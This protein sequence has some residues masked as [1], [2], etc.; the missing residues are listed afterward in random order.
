ML[1]KELI[2]ILTTEKPKSNLK[3]LVFINPLK[4][5]KNLHDFISYSQDK[6]FYKYMETEPKNK[7]EIKNYFDRVIKNDIKIKNNFLSQKF[8]FVKSLKLDKIIGSAKLSD[9]SLERKS[10]QWG[11]GV[12]SNFRKYNYLIKIQL[13]LIDYIFNKIKFNRLWGQTHEK[14]FGVINS[15]K[16]LKFRDEGIKYDFYYDRKKNKFFNAYA[17]SFLKKDY[18]KHFKSNKKTNLNSDI[19]IKKINTIICDTLKIE[20]NLSTNIEMKNLS[21][22]DSLNHFEI[23]TSIEK[24]F[25]IRF[26]SNQ[27]IKLDSS[28]NI[29]KQIKS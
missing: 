14:N 29:L 13:S 20:K 3:D 1:K 21:K 26:T 4:T 18:D 7:K 12:A 6:N 9:F 5:K 8:W 17:Y 27:L 22:W 23:I 16:I 15:Q 25:K 11:Y 28:F 2:K 10:V 24:K 19:N